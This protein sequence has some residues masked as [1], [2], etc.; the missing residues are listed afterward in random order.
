[1]GKRCIRITARPKAVTDQARPCERNRRRVGQRENKH[2]NMS[3]LPS[4]A[5]L[6]P[7]LVTLALVFDSLIDNLP[8][9]VYHCLCLSF[10]LYLSQYIYH[11][12]SP[13][14][15]TIYLSLSLY[16]SLYLYVSFTHTKARSSHALC[17][18]A[19][20]HLHL[21]LQTHQMGM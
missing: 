9:Y 19:C 16:Y 12:L 13:S 4:W 14:L 17:A 6:S 3:F 20:F 21:S 8:F 1:M 7:S 5:L 18:C 15:P 11:Y 10:S 2:E